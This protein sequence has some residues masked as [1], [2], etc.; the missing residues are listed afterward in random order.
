MIGGDVWG[1]SGFA[2]PGGLQSWIQ[3]PKMKIPQTVE[4]RNPAT[5]QATLPLHPLH[6]ILEVRGY[7]D[8]SKKVGAVTNT[9]SILNE[10]GGG[11]CFGGLQDS[12]LQPLRSFQMPLE[13]SGRLFLP[14]VPPL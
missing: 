3:V 7:R 10:G 8:V 6:L 11:I 1:G 14:M 13:S 2:A 9:G 12:V 4:G 5:F